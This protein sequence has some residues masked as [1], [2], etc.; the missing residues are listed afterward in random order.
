[1][2]L[3]S[4]PGDRQIGRGGREW[5]A[6][7]HDQYLASRQAADHTG[8]TST[9]VLA[10]ATA[11]SWDSSELGREVELFLASAAVA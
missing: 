1:M 3:S 8:S 9:Q 5:H 11:L 6:G 7:G 4:R 2:P 10:A